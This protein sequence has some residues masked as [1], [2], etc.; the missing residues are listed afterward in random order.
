MTPTTARVRRA[1]TDTELADI[2]TATTTAT[3][4]AQV[5]VT[6][7]TGVYT[8]L[9]GHGLDSLGEQRLDPAGFA[10]PATQWLAILEAAT[11]CAE[12]WGTAAQIGLE[13]ANRMPSSYD[14]PT[15]PAP[16]LDLPDRRPAVHHLHVHRDAVDVMAACTH[17]IDDL[18]QY[19]GLRSDTYH[20]A[21][22]SWLRQMANLF[23]LGTGADTTVTADGPLS[24]FIRTASG[25]VYAVVFHPTPRVCTVTGCPAVVNDDGSTTTPTGQQ[26]VEDHEHQPSYPLGAPS[27]GQWH[28]H[29]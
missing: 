7:I 8:A 28:A 19:Y 4:P 1:L 6:A 22:N 3:S 25:L 12:Q 11:N 27:P 18:G 16:T 29:S 26:S 5:L 10:I 20:Q 15:V 17:Y 24:L 9:L 2:I 14:D 13:L 23:S 21:A